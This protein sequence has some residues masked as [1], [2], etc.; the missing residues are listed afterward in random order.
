M[1]N[2]LVEKIAQVVKDIIGNGC[3][4]RAMEVLKNNGIKLPAITVSK[5]GEP[6]TPAVYID[7]L[8]AEIE[9]GKVWVSEAAQM[10][11]DT[12]E[13]RREC[14]PYENRMSREGILANVEYQL[15]NYAKNRTQ[16]R[17]LP[18][19]KFLDLAVV[20]RVPIESDEPGVSFL[21][22]QGMCDLF[23]IAAEEL[24]AAAR[25]NTEKS[26]FVTLPFTSIIAE[27]SGK[28]EVDLDDEPSMWVFTTEKKFNGAAI[29]LFEA[30]FKELA[31][32]LGCDLYV[33]PSSVCEIIVLPA[34]G[35]NM[36]TWTLKTMVSD[37]NGRVVE[38]DQVLGDSVYRY[39]RKENRLTIVR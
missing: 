14:F 34:V 13:E 9:A 19:R 6:E 37:V 36:S 3:E 8:L 18:H 22:R 11:V 21:V 28:P 27:L 30:P 20:Y 25:I 32:R 16:L 17:G 1:K 7:H 24:D 15:I 5:P 38:E 2:M 35:I 10:I 39:I 31:D 26:G 12:Y 4:V 33:L 23:G 29:M